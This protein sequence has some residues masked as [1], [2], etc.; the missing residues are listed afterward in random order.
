LVWN[1]VGRILLREWILKCF[2]KGVFLHSFIF[3]RFYLTFHFNIIKIT[4]K[5]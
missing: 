3:A 4:V 2:L 5:R 1:Q